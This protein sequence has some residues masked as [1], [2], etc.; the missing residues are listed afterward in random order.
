MM[1]IK[2][3]TLINN[4]GLS[5]GI[6]LHPVPVKNQNVQL[7]PEHVTSCEVIVFLLRCAFQLTQN[8]TE[9]FSSSI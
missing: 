3:K 1:T 8:Q 5:P 4:K 6:S 9:H 7:G 2:T